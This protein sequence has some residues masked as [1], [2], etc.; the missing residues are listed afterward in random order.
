MQLFLYIIFWSL[1]IFMLLKL[2]STFVSIFSGSPS[3]ETS[4]RTAYQIFK[5]INPKK[6]AT[7]YDLGCGLGNVGTEIAHKFPLKVV[8]YEISPLPY[9]S[10][11]VRSLFVKNFRVVYA[12][13]KKINYSDADIVY[14]YLLPELLAQ[15]AIKFKT[16]LKKDSIVISLVFEIKGLA[17]QK[18]IIV[19]GKKVHIYKI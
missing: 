3:G 10:S 5:Y 18:T 17:K 16:E 4:S 8:G 7:I 1:F 6:N 12:N 11:K 15:L 14:C 9:L 2:I 13:I 19:D